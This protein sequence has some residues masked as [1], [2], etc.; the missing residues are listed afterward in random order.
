VVDKKTGKKMP[1]VDTKNLPG[2]SPIAGE[3]PRLPVLVRGN[4]YN[5]LLK[6]DEAKKTLDTFFVFKQAQEDIGSVQW[7]EE[8]TWLM[9]ARATKLIAFHPKSKT[10]ETYSSK[11]T[12]K[13]YFPDSTIEQTYIDKNNALWVVCSNGLYAF[14]LKSGKAKYINP[15]IGLDSAASVQTCV[16]DNSGMLWIASGKLLIRYNPLKQTYRK[17]NDILTFS[18]GTFEGKS[19]KDNMGNLFFAT[20]KGMLV[21]NPDEIVIPS[22]VPE[23]YIS[24]C[25]IGNRLLGN[26]EMGELSL[27]K[28]IFSWNENFLNFEVYTDQLIGPRPHR[29]YYRLTGLD[30]AWIDN[31]ASNQIRYTNLSHGNYTL[32]IKLINGYGIQSKI[33]R[34]TFT[35]GRPFWLTWWFISLIVLVLVIAFY[36]FIKLRERAMRRKQVLLEKIISDRTAEVVNKAKEIQNQKEIIEEKNKELTDSIHYAQ[37]IQQSILPDEKTMRKYLP[38]HFVYFRPKDIVSGDFYWFSQ[39]KDS[40]MW[41]LVDCTG[42]GVPGGFMSMLGSGLLNQIVNEELHVEPGVVLDE[43]RSRVIIALKQTGAIGENRDGMDIAF[44]RYIPS[45]NMVQFA[46]A[47][48]SL[49]LINNGNLLEFKGDK[50]PIGIYVGEKKQFTCQEIQVKKGDKLYMSS[51]GYFDQFGGEKGKK[52]KSSSFEKLVQKINDHNSAEQLK[53][54]DETFIAWRGDY[55]QVDDVCVIGVH[56]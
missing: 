42:H 48:N 29:V 2:T 6:F 31:G 38:E 27:G 52:F 24:T 15:L 17:M 46:G 41:A 55:E 33:L 13:F 10:Y 14:D 43:L 51:D 34:L 25:K 54:L 12:G 28:K 39:Q 26:A 40:V 11:G 19:G 3:D 20:V 56:I 9:R 50:Q 22:R 30:S 18:L 32:E 35:I 45:K 4:L 23:L 37:R 53:C 44:C 36:L 5:V 47:N 7:L 21:I 16:M 8:D 1:T 49:Y